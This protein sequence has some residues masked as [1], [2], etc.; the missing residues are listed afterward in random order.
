MKRF[1][2]PLVAALAIPTAVNANVGPKIAE[3]LQ[4]VIFEFIEKYVWSEKY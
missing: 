3:D 2:I 4:S 1:L